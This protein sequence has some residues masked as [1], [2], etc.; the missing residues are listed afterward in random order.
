MSGITDSNSSVAFISTN[1]SIDEESLIMPHAIRPVINVKK[2]FV[3]L[4]SKSTT[5]K[6][7]N[8]ASKIKCEKGDIIN[9]NNTKFY[10]LRDSDEEDFH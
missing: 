4:L 6:E 7:Y 1:G 5:K 9:Y 8:M 10:V 3:E 2:E